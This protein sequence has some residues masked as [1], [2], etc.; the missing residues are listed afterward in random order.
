[1]AGVGIIAID[2]GFNTGIVWGIVNPALRDRTS[3]WNAV[4]RARDFGYLQ[5]GPKDPY[6]GRTPSDGHD[7]T[8]MAVE[9]VMTRIFHWHVERGMG[10]GEIIVS[11]ENF[12]VRGIPTGADSRKGLTPVFLAGFLY[13]T[14]AAS[15]WGPNLHFVKAAQHKPYATDARMKRLTK[16]SRGKVGWIRGKPHTRD[17]VRIFCYESNQLV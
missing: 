11:C 13:G 6:K 4:A 10:V 3:N 7:T 15:G 14:M 16:A 17:A 2:P 5:M 9:C 8:L 1:M 12:E